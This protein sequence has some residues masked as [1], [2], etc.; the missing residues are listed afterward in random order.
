ML[1]LVSV[2]IRIFGVTT[3][4]VV[5]ASTFVAEIIGDLSKAPSISVPVVGGH[6]GV[7]VSAVSSTNSVRDVAVAP[8]ESD[9]KLSRPPLR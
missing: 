4:D 8:T 1:T 9:Q 6:S 3:L 5:R 7:T 2:L